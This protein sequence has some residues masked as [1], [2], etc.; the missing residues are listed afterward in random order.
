MSEKVSD[1]LREYLVEE[2][3][4]NPAVN[5]TTISK[6]MDIP[7]STFN[8]LLN[9]YSKPSVNTILKLSQFIPE[10]KK[11]I[12]EEVMKVIEVTVER[13]TFEYAGQMLETLLSDKYLF[14][15]WILAFSTKGI[16]EEEIR[17][18]FGRQG[19]SAL[20][21]LE[22]KNILSKDAKGFYKVKE[23]NRYVTFSFRLIKA[24][25][26]FLVEQYK[27]DNSTK[28]HIHY[29]VQSLNE[30]GRL[31]VIKAHQIFHREIRKIMD[32]EENQGDMPYFSMGC[33]DI[34]SEK[35]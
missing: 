7:P 6:K 27:P 3:Q 29:W 22:K 5:E 9:G 8:R 17:E 30:T 25:L 15:C 24:H 13:D 32:D 19:L 20:E 16:T 33:S 2:R 4:K 26:I 14:L 1:I 18:D 11:A 12:P 23:Q 21:M 35:I 10:L 28:N 31:K 34:L